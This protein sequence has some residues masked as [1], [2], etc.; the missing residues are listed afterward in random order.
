MY[1]L[2]LHIHGLS[3][4][5]L[6]IEILQAKMHRLLHAMKSPQ[7][8]LKVVHIAGSKGKGSVAAMLSS[9]LHQAGLKV[10]TYTRSAASLS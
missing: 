3:Q 9:I 2:V 7:K 10:G 6:R 4:L 1:L 8:S 5:S